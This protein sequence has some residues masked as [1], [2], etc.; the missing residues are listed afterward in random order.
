MSASKIT[1]FTCNVTIVYE[2]GDNSTTAT[3]NLMPFYESVMI[4]NIDGLRH[5][6]TQDKL[7]EYLEF[8]INH[9]E[10]YATQTALVRD[11]K[12]EIRNFSVVARGNPIPIATDATSTSA[13]VNT[14]ADTTAAGTTVKKASPYAMIS[15]YATNHQKTKLLI[16]EKNGA[17]HE[18]MAVVRANKEQFRSVWRIKAEYSWLEQLTHVTTA[19]GSNKN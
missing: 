16:R 13:T 4:S 1:S 5:K 8:C 7:K 6:E 10:A 14:A 2:S 15:T 9:A 19:F 17:G 12:V 3:V 18:W 11:A